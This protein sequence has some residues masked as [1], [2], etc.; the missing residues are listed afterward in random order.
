MLDFCDVFWASSRFNEV[1]LGALSADELDRRR[2]F[3]FS[4]DADVFSASR[5]LLRLVLA[6]R[7][8]QT[9]ADLKF[10][11]DCL[12][13]PRPHGKPRLNLPNAQV[14]FNVSHSAGVVVVAVASVE[15][16]VDIEAIP[17]HPL[18]AFEGMAVHPMELSHFDQTEMVDQP[19]EQMRLWTRKEATLKA[20]GV[21]LVVSPRDISVGASGSAPERV[22][23]DGL[24]KPALPIWVSDIDFLRN[25]ACSIAT[26]SESPHSV[27]LVDAQG[28]L[29]LSRLARTGG[30][31]DPREEVVG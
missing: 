31:P 24:H 19:Q 26:M 14:H 6:D 15:V 18:D 10:T 29:T 2:S 28:L 27:R 1:F 8:G 4:Q 9:P 5:I 20:A 3:R 22:Q 23:W 21:G 13:C 17:T 16:G 25:Y 11:R 12:F 30:N 7:I